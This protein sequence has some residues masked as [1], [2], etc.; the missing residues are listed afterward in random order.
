MKLPDLSRKERGREKEEILPDFEH[1]VEKQGTKLKR[2][3]AA[4]A[5][6]NIALLDP[7]FKQKNSSNRDDEHI[8]TECADYPPTA[9]ILYPLHA[10]RQPIFSFA[11]PAGG[12]SS[13]SSAK[14]AKRQRPSL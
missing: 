12:S 6:L 10:P 9:Y 14:I 11:Y 7:K 4:P 8:P 1:Y 3:R 2:S 13:S 5:L